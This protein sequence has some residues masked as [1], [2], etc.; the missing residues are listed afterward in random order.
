MRKRIFCVMTIAMVLS[1]VIIVTGEVN[2]TQAFTNILQKSID[3]L[4]VELRH[5]FALFG[6]LSGTYFLLICFALLYKF[7]ELF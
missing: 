1:L 5:G 3:E 2:M 7:H 6:Y 4:V